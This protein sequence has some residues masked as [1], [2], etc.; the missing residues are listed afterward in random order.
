M[1]GLMWA[2]RYKFPQ[3][4]E[5][6]TRENYNVFMIWGVFCIV[7]T[8]LKVLNVANAAH[9]GGL[10]YGLGVGWVFFDQ[11]YRWR[12]IAALIGLAVL[13]T[14]SLTYA[15]WSERW[16]FWKAYRETDLGH[17]DASIKWYKQSLKLGGDPATI[18]HNIGLIE[19]RRNNQDEKEKAENQERA[20]NNGR[21][22]DEEISPPADSGAP[23]STGEPS[24]GGDVSSG[25]A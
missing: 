16:T 2:A 17:Y 19:A 4:R 6:A 18:W 24:S 12:G 20:A 15:P 5:I 25:G 14:C 10:L 22:L 8:W 3:W 11:R 9:F 21:L 1:F 23:P 7:A 13:V